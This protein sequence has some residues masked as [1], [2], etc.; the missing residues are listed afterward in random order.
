MKRGTPIADVCQAPLSRIA[1][2]AFALPSTDSTFDPQSPHTQAI[3]HLGLIALLIFCLIFAIVGGALFYGIAHFRGRE[4]DPDPHQVAGNRTVEIIWTAIPVLIVLLLFG[5]TARTMAVADPPPP[6][7]PDLVVT[8]HQF[9]WE[10]RYAASGV[11]VANEIH[12]PTGKAFSIQLES[13]DVVHEFWVMELTRK[14]EAVPGQT[15]H[16]WMQ[17]DHPGTYLG[18]CSEFCG[19]QH[20]WMRFLVVAEDPARFAAW[21]AAQLQP[22]PAP[23]GGLAAGGLKLF[24]GM[25]CM[26]C[27]AIEGVPG[28]N[29]RVGPDLTH[30]ASRRQLGGGV[31]ENT[32]QNLRRW[33]R[34]PLEVKPGVLMPDF[35]LSDLQLNE[36]DA[37]FETLK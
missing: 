30:I 21:Q 20:A 9:W 31:C 7:N 25:S 6:A 29:A 22:A 10:A 35:N 23:A 26:D 12:I 8:G 11:I 16:I 19:V 36:L 18:V 1:L 5:L 4:G 33:L 28:A 37:Y 17:A 13:K 24:E 14:M 15:R 2:A 27:H 34:N 3:Y 32:P